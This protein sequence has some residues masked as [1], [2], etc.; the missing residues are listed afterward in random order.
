MMQ[1]VDLM[2][3][4][5]FEMMNKLLDTTKVVGTTMINEAPHEVCAEAEAS[6][7]KVTGQLMVS[8]RSY[9]RTLEHTHLGEGAS[10]GW[11]PAPEVVREHVDHD[12]AS[13]MAK[14]VFSSWCHKV[15]QAIP[16]P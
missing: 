9:L 16:E 8:L 11:L 12:E 15:Q 5:V 1:R 6:H 10:A 2:V 13:E 4:P 7:D 14:D 3:R